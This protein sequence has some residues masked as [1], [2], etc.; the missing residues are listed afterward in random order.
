M[1]LFAKISPSGAPAGV[2]CV[3]VESAACGEG[4]PENGQ[5]KAEKG[6]FG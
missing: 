5:L 1:K 6:S 2:N 3:R 4:V